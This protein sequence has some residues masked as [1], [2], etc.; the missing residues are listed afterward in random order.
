MFLLFLTF[1]VLESTWMRP[2]FPFPGPWCLKS[3]PLALHSQDLCGQARLQTE[4]KDL[5]LDGFIKECL[6]KKVLGTTDQTTLMNVWVPLASCLFLPFMF[7]SGFFCCCCFLYRMR[8][9]SISVYSNPTSFKLHLNCWLV[10]ET[11]PLASA[12]KNS[13]LLSNGPLT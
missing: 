2:Y 12:G 13:P 4:V 8:P 6:S 9:P 5:R 3:L 1:D 10:L 7:C 11:T